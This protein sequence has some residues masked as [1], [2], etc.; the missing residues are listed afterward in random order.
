MLQVIVPETEFGNGK[1]RRCQGDLLVLGR[2]QGQ[3]FTTNDWMTEASVEL[4]SRLVQE[5]WR[6]GVGG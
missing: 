4:D 1:Q 3:K 5:V 2:W 6:Q